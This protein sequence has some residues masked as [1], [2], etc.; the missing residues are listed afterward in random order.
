MVTAEKIVTG[1]KR[2]P[3]GIKEHKWLLL[4]LFISFIIFITGI[5]WGLPN[6]ESWCPDSLAPFHPL[7]GLSRFFSFG[8]FNKYPQVHQTILAVLNLPVVIT[9][10]INSNPFNNF[11]ILKFLMIIRS[12]PMRQRLS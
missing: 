6:S 12:T 1:I 10:I 2:L 9:A 4:I 11:N 8:Y 3:A 5:E 7:L